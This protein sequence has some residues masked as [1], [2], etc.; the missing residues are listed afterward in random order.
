MNLDE[1]L[2]QLSHA[3]LLERIKREV[4]RVDDPK[5]LRAMILQLVDLNETQKAIF[6][7]LLH[8]LIDEDPEAQK[9]FE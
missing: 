7:K 1:I 3:F 6:R 5:A 2:D 4:N 8:E 9:L